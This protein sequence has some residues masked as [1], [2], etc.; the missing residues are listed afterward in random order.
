MLRAVDSYYN[1]TGSW[2]CVCETTIYGEN[3]FKAEIY[4]V[5][6]ELMSPLRIP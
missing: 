4:S 1:L 2:L 5:F 3:D 6:D